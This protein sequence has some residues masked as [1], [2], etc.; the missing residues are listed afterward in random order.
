M[1][2]IYKLIFRAK[3]KLCDILLIYKTNIYLLVFLGTNVSQD[4]IGIP[5]FGPQLGIP[6][7]KYGFRFIIAVVLSVP[8]TKTIGIESH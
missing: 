6:E 5:I 7:F 8:W 3:I 1:Y 4:A 2:N